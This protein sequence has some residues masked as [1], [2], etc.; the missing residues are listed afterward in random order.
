MLG[1]NFVYWAVHP[2]PK[3][4]ISDPPPEQ[5]RTDIEADKAATLGAANELLHCEASTILVIRNS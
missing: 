4:S 5:A 1:W 2:L 3:V